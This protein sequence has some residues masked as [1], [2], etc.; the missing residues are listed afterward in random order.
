M[1]N[2][3]E[4][5]EQIYRKITFHELMVFG[6]WRSQSY[7]SGGT[8]SLPSVLLFSPSLPSPPTPALDAPLPAALDAAHLGAGSGG[9]SPGKFLNSYIA[10]GEF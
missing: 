8:T 2:L 1:Y 3:F 7:E 10:V 4:F 9:F 6:Q 5:A